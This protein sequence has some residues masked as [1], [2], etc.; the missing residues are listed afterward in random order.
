MN[1]GISG[2]ELTEYD[3]NKRKSEL[4]SVLIDNVL[5]KYHLDNK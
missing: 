1:G 2:E 4:G 5:N 3:I